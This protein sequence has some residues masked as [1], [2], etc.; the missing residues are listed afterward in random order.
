MS[1]WLRVLRAEIGK[2]PTIAD[3]AA[4]SQQW[5]G[6]WASIQPDWRERDS[7]DRL[8]AGGTG[9]WDALKKPGKNGLR[10]VLLSLAWWGLEVL[11]T[12]QPHYTKEAHEDWNHA[13]K[14]VLWVISEMATWMLNER[15]VPCPCFRDTLVTQL[16]RKH[17]RDDGEDLSQPAKRRRGRL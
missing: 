4:Y 16:C 3:T 12:E 1:H 9:P 15:Y 5:C 8:I 11:D 2:E 6:W 14:D 13:V 10:I 7:A 17:A